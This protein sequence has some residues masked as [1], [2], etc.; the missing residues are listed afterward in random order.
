MS[1]ICQ[2]KL[3]GKRKQFFRGLKTWFQVP[4]QQTYWTLQYILFYVF[5]VC[6]IVW[7][8]IVDLNCIC[9]K[10][11]PTLNKVYTKSTAN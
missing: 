11:A 9:A 2:S 4:P 3:R 10:Q 6:S 1:T 8:L 5:T 7:G